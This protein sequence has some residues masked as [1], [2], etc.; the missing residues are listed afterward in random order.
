[1]GR[2]AGPAPAVSPRSAP[3]RAMAASPGSGSANPRKFSE[4]IAL[5][6]QRQAEETRAFEQLMTDLTLSRV[7]ARAG[8]GGG[9]HGHG[10]GRAGPGRRVRGRGP[11]AGTGP[12]GV[13]ERGRR[14]LG[15][16]FPAFRHARAVEVGGRAAER[17]R[18]AAGRRRGTESPGGSHKQPRGGQGGF[19]APNVHHPVALRDCRAPGPRARGSSRP[20]RALWAG[21]GLLGSGDGDGAPSRV[22][23]FPISS[24]PRCLLYRPAFW[25]QPGDFARTGKVHSVAG[26]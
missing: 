12:G 10:R 22:G 24:P 15:A 9:G 13:R 8:A 23:A 4:K 3:G 26:D 14:G 19:S 5:H 7:R 11:E 1:M 18:R 6:T 20:S 2:T 21:A 17:A 25:V 16:H